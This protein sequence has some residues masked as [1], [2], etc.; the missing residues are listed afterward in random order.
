MANTKIVEWEKPY[1]GGT[2]IEVDNVNKI[3][4]L[5]LR[6]EDNLLHVNTDNELY[7]DLQIANGIAPTDDFEVWV[8]TGIVNAN[9]GR[10]QNGLLLHYETTSW[11]YAQWLYGADGKLYFDGWTWVW[12]HI[13]YSD[14][15]DTLLQNLRTYVDQQLALKVD[16]VNTPNQL[17]ATSGTGTQITIN[18]KT[19]AV[20]YIDWTDGNDSNDGWELTPYQTWSAFTTAHGTETDILVR[21]CNLDNTSIA[22]T[23]VQWWT[24]EWRGKGSNALTALTNS[25]SDHLIIRGLNITT[26]SEA[27]QA[28]FNLVEECTLWDMTLN[29][30]WNNQTINEIRKCE[31]WHI[32]LTS[33]MYLLTDTFGW[34]KWNNDERIITQNWWILTLSACWWY[35][36]QRAAWTLTVKDWTELV[37][38]ATLWAW[39]YSLISN[40]TAWYVYLLDWKSPD[41]INLWGTASYT[42]WKFVFDKDNSTLLWTNLDEVLTAK[43][44]VDSQTFQSITP[45]S[46]RQEDINKALDNQIWTIINWWYAPTG[47]DRWLV[48]NAYTGEL[49]YQLTTATVNNGWTWYSAWDVLFFNGID[50]E[51]VWLMWWCIVDTVDANGEIQAVLIDQK[52]AYTADQSQIWVMT[53]TNGSWTWATLNITTTAWT[54]STTNSIWNPIVWDVC[55]VLRNEMTTNK[56]TWQFVYSDKDGDG[57]NEWTPSRPLTTWQLQADNITLVSNNWVLSVS[58]SVMDK[59][60][61]SVYLTTNQTINW[62]KTFTTSPVVPN[63]TAD[64]WNTWTAIATEAQVYKKIDKVTWWTWDNLT[65]LTNDGQVADSWIAKGDVELNTNKETWSTLTDNTSKYPSS[66]TVL[67]AIWALTTWVSSVN[68]QTWAVTLDADDIS[69]TWTTNQ[70]TNDTEKNTWNGKQDALT[71]PATPTQWNLVVWWAN[72]KTLVDGWAIPT[73]DIAY[74]EFEFE[75]ATSWATLTVSDLNTNFTPNQN[76]TIACGTVKEWMQYIVRITTDSTVYTMSLWT[77]ITNPFGEDL[78]L[79]ANKTTTFVFLAT[80]SNTLELFSARTAS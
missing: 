73:W 1:T 26:Y 23:D 18:D 36:I 68:W 22:I 34:S 52:W 48:L 30:T 57:N 15:V 38:V 67:E 4:S 77:W 39:T 47:R 19:T 54:G 33:W 55:T 27:G 72:N 80:S 41:P 43:Q 58:N 17:Y 13:Y 53:T 24:I 5:L 65:S 14:E 71:L 79:T 64:A 2:A 62:T 40:D 46:S 9:D 56:W 76:F 45:D 6:S 3:I 49:C 42:L 32:T 25:W 59:V 35:G 28:Y 16:K 44:L 50:P 29:M 66:H 10:D 63:K 51:E 20:Y 69:D 60:N 12:K 74:S 70:W 21:I 75:T 7:C 61:N 37:K 8:T 11:A 78:T 31:T